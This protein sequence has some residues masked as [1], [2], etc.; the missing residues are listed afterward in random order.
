MMSLKKKT[1]I[2]ILL[3]LFTFLLTSC[4]TSTTTT[5][6]EDTSKWT[7]TPTNDVTTFK[8][9][10]DEEYYSYIR[11]RV[12]GDSESLTA[13]DIYFPNNY[14]EYE[15]LNAVL[16]IH[17][18]A[19]ISESKE[20][21][22]SFVLKIAKELFRN[23]K[24]CC[25]VNLNYRLISMNNDSASIYDMLDDI[26][27]CMLDVKALLESNGIEL[28]KVMIG[29]HS[30]GGH[31]SLLYGYKKNNEALVKVDCVY[32]LSG[33]TDMK[34]EVYSQI[35]TNLLSSF[36]PQLGTTEGVMFLAMKATNTSTP[37]DMFNGLIDVSPINYGDSALPTLIFHGDTD[38][39]VPIENSR[40]LKD[41]LILN[42]VYVELNEL[43]GKNHLDTMNYELLNE[44]GFMTKFISFYETYIE[45]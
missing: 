35:A 4:N 16:F 30:A 2:S 22:T 8:P 37:E 12:Y 20:T 27:D 39:I 18:G 17:G 34:F 7:R 6:L 13:Y 26:E 42:G 3:F 15:T 36:Y 38:D 5:T 24:A 31:L 41:E 1:I 29:G 11:H 32:S 9:I 10:V 40:S 33:P 45:S 23:D 19:W 25:V 28:G 14:S 21:Y 44:F 43:Q